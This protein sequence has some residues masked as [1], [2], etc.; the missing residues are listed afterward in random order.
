MKKLL[1]ITII[2][3]FFGMIIF[4]S[5]GIQIQNK[6]IITSSRGNTFYVGGNGSGNYSKIQDAIDNAN[7]G[8]TV[9]VYDDSS[10]Y[11][12]HVYISNR[13]NLIGE[14]RDTTVIIGTDWSYSVVY[15]SF[16]TTNVLVSGFTMTDS[17]TDLDGCTGIGIG[18]SNNI[19]DGNNIAFNEKGIV[20]A[21]DTYNNEIKNNLI[22]HNRRV[23]IIDNCR[24]STN[25][26]TWNV[27]GGNGR[28]SPLHTEG[29]IIKHRSGGYFHHNDFDLN[30]GCNVYTETST[31]GVWDDGAEGNFWDD[32]KFNKGYPDVYIIPAW[33]EDQV[34]W[35][36]SPSRYF[37]H[38]IVCIKSSYKKNPGETIYLDAHINVDSSSVTWFWDFG[39]GNTSDENL[40]KYSY[41]KSGIYQINVTVTNN[42]GVSDSGKSTAYIGIPPDKPTIKGPTKGQVNRFYNY[43]IV[44]N[45]SDSDFI[46]Y[47]VDW[48]D[49]YDDI[50]GPVPSGEVVNISH[51]WRHASNYTITVK[52][53]DETQRESEWAYL[54]VRIP[55]NKGIPNSLFLRFLNHF[56][57]LHRLLDI[58]RSN[59]L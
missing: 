7:D 54:T 53:I 31:W 37:N 58:W 11:Y 17:Y 1:A 12:E 43:S 36:P 55:R 23:G 35:H 20:L 48:D 6:P 30:W 22:I 57:L 19:I 34:D 3:I 47:Y 13:L 5:T 4:P 26:V 32:W 21:E 46:T 49:I 40:I 28:E 29:G 2:F 39:D 10:P 8:D 14:N 27:I 25:K 9:F 38:P 41:N 33:L 45:D 24:D 18:G 56:P 42:Q 44:T 16:L 51:F 59:L 52:A 15:L 50:I